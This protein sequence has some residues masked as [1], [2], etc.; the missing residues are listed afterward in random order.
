MTHPE[1]LKQLGLTDEVLQNLL[2]KFRVFYASLTPEES[3]VVD[4][5][6]P[7][8]K[9]VATLFGGDFTRDEMR[10]LL[11]PPP[12]PSPSPS[13]GGGPI[14]VAG[15]VGAFGQN[16]INQITNPGDGDGNGG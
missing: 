15:A 12:S 10:T 3:A 2:L 16:G 5:L 14:P 6:M 7:R 4:R 9:R 13:P 11:A 8:F 1:M